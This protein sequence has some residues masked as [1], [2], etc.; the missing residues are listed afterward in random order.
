MCDFCWRSYTQHALVIVAA[1]LVAG[2]HKSNSEFE[3]GRKAE[4]IQDYD[5]ALIHYERA[6]R[7]DPADADY[8][9]RVT[10]VRYAAASFHLEQGQKAQQ[11]GAKSSTT[12]A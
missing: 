5:T 12:S 3:A 10:H 4:A 9:L 2:C 8:K 1:V 7:S 11:K 6:E